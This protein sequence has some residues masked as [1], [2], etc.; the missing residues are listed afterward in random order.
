ME[1]VFGSATLVVQLLLRAHVRSC[2]TGSPSAPS[3]VMPMKR[4]W[5]RHPADI[6]FLLS[7]ELGRDR[8]CSA[9]CAGC[10][11]W[12][13]GTASLHSVTSGECEEQ[14]VLCASGNLRATIKAFALISN[15]RTL[16][17]V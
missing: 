5:G 6:P 2:S 13:M 11:Y 16:L 15:K 9:S 17:A 7:V 3:V 10:S 8:T 14:S 1:V 12:T 4:I